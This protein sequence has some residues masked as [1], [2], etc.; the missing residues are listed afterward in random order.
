MEHLLSFK[1]LLVIFI[2]YST[3]LTETQSLTSI[4]RLSVTRSRKTSIYDTAALAETEEVKTFYYNQTLD[5]FNYRPESYSTFQQK[6]MMNSKYWGGAKTSAPIFAY[7]GAEEAIDASVVNQGFLNDNA[8]SFRALLVH[9]EHRYYGDSI[10]FGSKK[11]AFENASTYGYLNS[12]QALADYAEVLVHIKNTLKAQESPVIVIGGSYGGMLAAW[13]RLKYP[14]L[15]LGALASSAPLLEF[16]DIRPQDNYYAVVTKD[17]RETSE[18]CYETILKSWSEIDRVASQPNGLSILSK[19]FNTCSPLTDAEG[20]K[21]SLQMMY[22]YAAQYDYNTYPTTQVA[23]ICGAIDGAS[24]GNDILSKISAGAQAAKGE[25]NC[26]SNVND[27]EPSSDSVDFDNWGWQTCN[28]MVMPI[29]IGN[30]TMFPPNPFNIEGF[31][32]QCKRNYGVSPRP[33]WVTTY[34][35]GH[36]IKRVLQRFGSNIIF[37]NGLRDPYSSGG[38]LDNL[39]DSLIASHTVNGSHCLDLSPANENDP[40]W[41]V[42]QRKEEIEIINSWITQYY[43]DLS[44]LSRRDASTNLNMLQLVCDHDLYDDDVDIDLSILAECFIGNLPQLS[45]GR[46]LTT[47]HLAYLATDSAMFDSVSPQ[48]LHPFQ[49]EFKYRVEENDPFSGCPSLSYSDNCYLYDFSIKG[50]ENLPFVE[51]VNIDL[52]G[53][54]LHEEF[55]KATNLSLKLSKLF[56]AMESAKFLSLSP[57][58]IQALS[59][60]PALLDGRSTPFTGLK[61]L[62]LIMNRGIRFSIPTHVMAYLF[63]VLE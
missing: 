20:L 23:Q 36:D 49:C 10:P 24:F 62:E 5:H 7:L 33:H 16:Y 26:V 21:G 48:H 47:L 11:E 19:R 63:T 38:V 45:A 6:Y 56:E 30:N 22:S 59:V 25:N 17:F 27:V 54:R 9:I 18:T 53:F 28:E 61:N 60:V 57:Q 14:H 32:D 4:P 2:I 51:R 31:V 37:S 34:Y 50:K 58:I 42:R 44:M 1:W 35:G 46:S 15:A 40:V 3:C 12:A 41:L 55:T 39:S 43:A 8:A 29:G 52:G 13:F